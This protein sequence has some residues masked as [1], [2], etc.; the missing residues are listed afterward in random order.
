METTLLIIAVAASGITAGGM[1]LVLFAI[2]PTRR[3]L[4]PERG[5]ELHQ[6][7]TP[8]IDA[9]MPPSVIVAL[10]S[11]LIVLIFGD[12]SSDSIA[13]AVIGVVASAGVAFL[14]VAFNMPTNKRVARWQAPEAD[15]EEVFRR[16]NTVHTLRTLCAVAAFLAFDCAAALLG[17]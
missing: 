4:S 6:R 3:E 14:S 15:Y 11:G 5:L 12:L 7:T 2:I 10:I 13:G 16:W 9:L 1:L 17:A 8:R